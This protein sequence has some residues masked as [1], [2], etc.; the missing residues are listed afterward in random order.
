MPCWRMTLRPAYMPF[1]RPPLFQA[2]KMIL[3][4]MGRVNLEGIDTTV[5]GFAFVRK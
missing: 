1:Q 3:A 4:S 2:A 5:G